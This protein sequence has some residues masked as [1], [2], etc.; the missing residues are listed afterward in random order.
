MKKKTHNF[1]E[2]SKYGDNELIQFI[3]THIINANDS[4]P[5]EGVSSLYPPSVT[6]PCREIIKRFKNYKKKL[7][8]SKNKKILRKKYQN[9]KQLDSLQNIFLNY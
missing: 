8:I 2:F 4:D 9:K 5:Y 3:T 6:I 1:W 7:N